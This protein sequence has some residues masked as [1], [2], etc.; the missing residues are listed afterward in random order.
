MTY[1][2][3]VENER[4]RQI[5]ERLG[6]KAKVARDL[7]VARELVSRRCH[8]HTL[9]DREAYLALRWLK[10]RAYPIRERRERER[11]AI[12]PHPCLLR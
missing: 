12:K 7:G 9:V 5:V 10:A 2:V 6:P 4:Y 11:N 8:G 1:P 3:T